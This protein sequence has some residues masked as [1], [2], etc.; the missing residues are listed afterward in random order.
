MLFFIIFAFK[1]LHIN[2]DWVK[3]IS[4]LT[5]VKVFSDAYSAYAS[6]IWNSTDTWFVPLFLKQVIWSCYAVSVVMIFF[7]TF[8]VLRS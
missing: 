7:I 3:I 6:H 1:A 5:I 2:E 8:Q 4:N